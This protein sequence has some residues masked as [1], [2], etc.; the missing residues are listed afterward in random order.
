MMEQISA[1]ISQFA[2]DPKS[3]I[4]LFKEIMKAK[5]YAFLQPT[6]INLEQQCPTPG[7]REVLTFMRQPE[8]VW[9][10][11]EQDPN[12]RFIGIPVSR[13]IGKELYP[14]V[15]MRGYYVIGKAETGHVAMLKQDD[16]HGDLRPTDECEDP[17][18]AYAAGRIKEKVYRHDG[19]Y[20][21]AAVGRIIDLR[22]RFPGQDVIATNGEGYLGQFAG[23]V[24]HRGPFP[25]AEAARATRAAV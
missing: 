4:P 12:I 6:M 20:W 19:S 1:M 25:D 16:V 17:R 8:W 7:H 13:M 11:C 3:A 21:I 10:I 15:V 14:Q 9:F 23:F 22:L 24:L 5:G 18:K 2:A